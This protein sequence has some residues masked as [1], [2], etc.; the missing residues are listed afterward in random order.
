M[1]IYIVYYSSLQIRGEFNRDSV[2]LK[3][4]KI[5]P[6]YDIEKEYTPLLQVFVQ[7]ML[8]YL[9]PLFIVVETNLKYFQLDKM[10]ELYDLVSQCDL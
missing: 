5:P 2:E 7:F 9:Q 3:I 6:Q 1:D 10:M 8:I 4:P